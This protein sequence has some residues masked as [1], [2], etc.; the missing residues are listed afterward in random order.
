[1]QILITGSNGQLGSTLREISPEYKD[2]EFLFT[3]INELDITSGEAIDKYFK[4]H[5]IDCLIN[6]AGYTAVDQAES[7]SA[8]A[9]LLNAKAVGFLAA[10]AA[11]AGAIMIHISTDYV[12]DGKSYRPYTEVDKPNPLSAYGKSKLNGELELI[13]NPGRNL[14]LRTSWLYSS[15]GHNFVK[16]ILNKAKEGSELKVVFDQVGT[17]TFA[18]DLARAMLEIIPRLPKKF[19]GL[20]YNYSNEGVASWYDFA[21]AILE[22]NELANPISPVLSKEFKTAAPRP[23]YSVLDKS[24]IRQDFG[25]KIPHWRDGLKRCM[26]KLM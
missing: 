5:K 19:R 20:I 6:C 14:I 10:A 16:T 21:H 11:K 12:F 1:M 26:E 3:D 17:P 25:L 4:Q 13:F 8:G 15:H 23:F 9:N 24:R 18:D 2:Y 22:S 7:D